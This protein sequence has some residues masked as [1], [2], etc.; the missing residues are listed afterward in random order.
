MLGCVSGLKA[1]TS[2]RSVQVLRAPEQ[3]IKGTS[4]ASVDINWKVVCKQKQQPV[5]NI[6]Y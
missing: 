1:P 3:S 5:Y 6:I 2:V 4:E